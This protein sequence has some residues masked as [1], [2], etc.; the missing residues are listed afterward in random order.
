MLVG[1]S[2][3]VTL[4]PHSGSR[5]LARRLQVEV[6]RPAGLTAGT[7]VGLWAGADRWPGRRMLGATRDP[8]AWHVAHFGHWARGASGAERLAP[9]MAPAAAQ[10]ARAAA[11]E[12]GTLASAARHAPA[13]LG[14][15]W[16][17]YVV[18]V[19][20]PGAVLADVDARPAAMSWPMQGETVAPA[21]W[22]A[23]RG[24]G[25]ATWG[26]VRQFYPR[27]LWSRG[28][29]DLIAKAPDMLADALV[30]CGQ[31]DAGLAEVSQVWGLALSGGA[32]AGASAAP[33][34]A[35]APTSEQA[36]RLRRAERLIYVLHPGYLDGTAPPV[37]W[38]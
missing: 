22:M 29:D 27:R 7:H 5:S 31:L 2:L 3:L 25:L 16:A 13:L 17:S 24:A 23:E 32:G 6:E 8:V 35:V 19:A 12:F 26:Y 36:E 37:V 9:W 4:A 15:L 18:G 11:A 38:A 21:R 10:A 14:Y 30:D 34:P 33:S 1:P 20:T 28:V